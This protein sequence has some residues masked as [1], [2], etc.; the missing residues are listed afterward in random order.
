MRCIPVI[1]APLGVVT[2]GVEGLAGDGKS[3]GEDTV[4]V[5]LFDV[6]QYRDG[7]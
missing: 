4:A 3:T 2:E 7:S 5:V 1:L 6:L